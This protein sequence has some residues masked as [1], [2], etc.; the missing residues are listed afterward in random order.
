M[1]F[2]PKKPYG[3]VFG[4]VAG[5]PNA[6]YTQ[7]GIYYDGQGNQVGDKKEKPKKAPAKTEP[8]AP[9][10]EADQ[11]VRFQ[12][13]KLKHAEKELKADPEN[14]DLQINVANAELALDAL[15]NPQ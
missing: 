2:D 6:A 1:S 7:D 9:N 13:E 5:A 3:Q 10:V 12:R 8:P 11:R 4:H 15:I 14:L